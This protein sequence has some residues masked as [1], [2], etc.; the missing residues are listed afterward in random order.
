VEAREPCEIGASERMND[1]LD[2]AVKFTSLARRF[3]PDQGRI[4]YPREKI[5]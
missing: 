1:R 3:G 2:F 4:N 5:E